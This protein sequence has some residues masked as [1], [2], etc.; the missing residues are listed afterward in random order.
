MFI[1]Q[2]FS[3][4]FLTHQSVSTIYQ[5]SV[6]AAWA[7]PRP[8]AAAASHLVEAACGAVL[9]PRGEVPQ[10][11]VQEVHQ[12]H[13]GLHRVRD[14]SG[15]EVTLGL[16]RQLPGDDG[17]RL[18][19]FDLSQSRISDEATSAMKAESNPEQ[20]TLIASRRS[21]S[22]ERRR[23]KPFVRKQLRNQIWR[24]FPQVASETGR[25]RVAGGLGSYRIRAKT[26]SSF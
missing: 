21:R 11:H 26:F 14:V 20:G 9:A 2:L 16:L 24:E 15:L 1:V 25:R 12:L 10:L 17:R 8:A 5:V 23:G 6:K 18:S 13:H 4:L 19:G 3:Q 7:G 22:A